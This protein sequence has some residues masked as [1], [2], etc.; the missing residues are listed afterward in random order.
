MIFPDVIAALVVAVIFSVVF[1]LSTWRRTRKS[2]L[3]WVFLIIFLATWAGGIWL[4]PFGP[5]LWGINWLSFLFIGCIVA[6]FISLKGPPSDA[7]R[8]RQETLDMLERIKEEK[9]IRKITYVTLSVVFWIL[10][11]VLVMAIIIRYAFV[12]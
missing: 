3:V 8:G 7:P 1:A 9:E 5:K 4:R 12:V 10:L 2:G 6:L 11:A